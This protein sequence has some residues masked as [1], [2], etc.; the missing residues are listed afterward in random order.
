MVNY[1]SR[2]YLIL[3]LYTAYNAEMMDIKEVKAQGTTLVMTGSIMSGMP[4]EVI[5]T[6]S[7]LRK[8]LSLLSWKV[9]F[10]VIRM[11]FAK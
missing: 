3:K 7:E 1:L 11:L 4:A 2:E 8:G 5:L 9:A 10:T 6:P